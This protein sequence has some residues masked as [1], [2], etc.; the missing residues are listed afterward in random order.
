MIVGIV[1][2]PPTWGIVGAKTSSRNVNP[3][4]QVSE[5]MTKMLTLLL[6]EIWSMTGI[7][8]PFSEN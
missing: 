5:G 4:P 7:L 3:H 6:T 2:P 1:A 8:Q